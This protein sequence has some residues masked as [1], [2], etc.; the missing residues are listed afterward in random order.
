[1]PHNES[2]SLIFRQATIDDYPNILAMY[3]AVKEHLGKTVDYCHWH[4]ENHPRPD[5]LRFHVE[6][7]N[8]WLACVNAD[9]DSARSRDKN[10]P[11]T[12]DEDTAGSADSG[13]AGVAD[14][15][16]AGVADSGVAGVADSGIA[17]VVDSG[18]LGAF[19][20]NH[21]HVSGAEK[22]PWKVLPLDGGKNI[23]VLHIFGV[24]PWAQGQGV[25]DFLVDSLIAQ[26]PRHGIGAIRLDAVTE[27]IPGRRLY[28]KH[29]FTDMGPFTLDYPGKKVSDFHLYELPLSI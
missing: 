25:A 7:G 18:I 19:A 26:A 4:S 28:E 5:D 21:E 29:G 3:E 17:G 1:M 2:T 8:M 24:A 14:S 13:V 6:A 15:G 20:V 27:N 12:S 9:C 10:A 16:V 11:S 22:A 23:W